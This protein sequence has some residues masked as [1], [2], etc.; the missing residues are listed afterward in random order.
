LVGLDGAAQQPPR[1]DDVLLADILGERARAHAR[2]QRRAARH[3][4]T[5]GGVVDVALRGK[6]MRVEQGELRTP[7]PIVDGA[8][9]QRCRV[10]LDARLER[11]N[12]TD[13]VENRQTN[14]RLRQ[15]GDAVEAVGRLLRVVVL[16]D[17]LFGLADRVLDL[18]QIAVEKVHLARR[19]GNPRAAVDPRTP[20]IEI[21]HSRRL[22]G[23]GL[24]NA[25]NVVDTKRRRGIVVDA[26]IDVRIGARRATRIRPTQH[27]SRHTG[28]RRQRIDEVEHD[29]PLVSR[30]CFRQ[31]HRQSPAPA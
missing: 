23:H 9:V 16:D 29:A 2:R 30:Q 31:R 5:A 28:R 10:S 13:R 24:G 21:R 22:D 4:Q 1:A 12:H 18:R 25:G 19:G 17:A 15:I 11:L 3:R 6:G 27:N 20:L 26:Q 14:V 7:Q 8:A